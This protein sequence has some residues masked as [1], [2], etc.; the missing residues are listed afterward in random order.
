MQFASLQSVSGLWPWFVSKKI[1]HRAIHCVFESS[2][3][4]HNFSCAVAEQV[5]YSFSDNLRKLSSISA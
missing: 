4:P 3:H 5:Q 1:Q 2:H